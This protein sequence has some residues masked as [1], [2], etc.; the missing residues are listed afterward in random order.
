[1]NK[2]KKILSRLC[3]LFRKKKTIPVV[4]SLDLRRMCLGKPAAPVFLM[5]QRPGEG[6]TA[7]ITYIPHPQSVTLFP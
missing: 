1:M 4:K 5:V 2:L 3:G 6:K 7:V